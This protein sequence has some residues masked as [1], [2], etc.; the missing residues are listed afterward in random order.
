MLSKSP[1]KL[2]LCLSLYSCSQGS[3]DVDDSAPTP[4]VEQEVMTSS[5]PGENRDHLDSEDTNST[6]PV[7]SASPKK[8]TTGISL[9]NGADITSITSAS[10]GTY[11]ENGTLE[12]Q[13][14]Y[15]G[16]VTVSGYPCF[17][18]TIG[19]QSRKA[20]YNSGTNTNTLT[21]RYVISSG[22]N[23]PDGISVGNQITGGSMNDHDD[24][25]AQRTLSWGDS[26]FS[27]VKVDTSTSITAPGQVADLI[28]SPSTQTTEL[29]LSWGVPE[30]NGTPIAHYVVQYKIDGESAWTTLDS[31]PT[32]ASTTI[33]NLEGGKTY[34]IRVAANNGL[35]GVF[36][37][38]ISRTLSAIAYDKFVLWYDA[39][40]LSTTFQ[41]TA[42]TVP[43]VNDGDSVAC[44]V[45]KSSS[46]MNATGALGPSLELSEQ[47]KLSTLSF[48]S[49]YLS[50]SFNLSASNY[51]D[52]TVFSVHLAD[53]NNPGAI[54]G[55]DDGG[56]D[57][58]LLDHGS[59]W[60]HLTDC[61]SSGSNPCQKSNIPITEQGVFKMVVITY[62]DGVVD[63][64][65]I[66]V[67]GSLAQ[68]FTANQTNPAGTMEIGSIGGG[69]DTRFRYQGDIAELLMYDGALSD[70]DRGELEGYL[71][72][73][74][75]LQASLP[76]DHSYK[77]NC[78]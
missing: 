5:Q 6:A 52:L 40:D 12:F 3:S 32:S 29:S 2:V 27:L 53:N 55:S 34:W 57:R 50:N 16:P 73:K 49:Q 25:P 54:W 65:A 8:T 15:E 19:N 68:S 21:F 36:S 48:N 45:D 20:C 47:N 17:D 23:D 74:W 63:G 69:G 38:P 42:C 71:A 60:S 35:Q 13:V 75:G 46:N 9:M 11:G 24:R 44:W 64:S 41:D 37:N 10:N 62:Q 39:A 58:F 77:T 7:G 30:D 1:F 59:I 14:H 67:D 56:W 76:N 31:N 66:H 33:Q 26:S 78:P 72:C 43:S 22:D 18:L 51:S 70:R 4:V 28:L 61:V